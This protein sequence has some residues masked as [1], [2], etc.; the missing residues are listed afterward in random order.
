MYYLCITPKQRDMQFKLP[1]FSRDTKLINDTVGFREQDGFVYY[2]HSGSPIYCHKKEDKNSYRHTL[3]SLIV[4]NLCTTGELSAALGINRK[5]I[6]RYTKAYR[7]HGPGY[8]FNRED[9]RGQCH[10]MT[11]ELLSVIQEK[12]DSGLSQ[13]RIAK[14]HGISDSA[15][16][17]HISNGNLKK[18]KQT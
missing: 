4:N 15:I 11:D 18:N 13:Y 8:F 9:N 16:A 14:D 10:K 12:L 5:N 1:L 2:I 7:E 17:Y 3:A 6:E